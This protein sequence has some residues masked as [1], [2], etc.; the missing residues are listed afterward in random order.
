ML[1]I[2]RLETVSCHIHGPRV[3]GASYPW[4]TI[5]KAPRWTQHRT[6]TTGRC[7]RCGW[8]SKHSPPWKCEASLQ[9]SDPSSSQKPLD[10]LGTVVGSRR[11]YY[12]CMSSTVIRSFWIRGMLSGLSSDFIFG[13]LGYR[14]SGVV[15]A[16][17]PQYYAFSQLWFVQKSYVPKNRMADHQFHHSSMAIFG[18]IPSPLD[19]PKWLV[20][21]SNTLYTSCSNTRKG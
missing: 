11:F 14:F 1:S 10:S 3:T 19:K 15:L 9:V 16:I 2:R 20:S 5:P 7:R 8:F 13:S 18:G 12:N 4:P 6:L 21:G 17:H